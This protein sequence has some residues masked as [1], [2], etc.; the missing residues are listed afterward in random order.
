MTIREIT[1]VY[2]KRVLE[3]KRTRHERAKALL[4][5]QAAS[6]DEVEEAELDMLEAQFEFDKA[7]AGGTD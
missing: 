4:A 6:Q 5:K 1:I 3:I 7:A 2:R